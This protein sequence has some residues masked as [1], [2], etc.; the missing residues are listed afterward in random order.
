MRRKAAAENSAAAVSGSK[1]KHNFPE[2]K[3]RVCAGNPSGGSCIFK[4]NLFGAMRRKA[5]AENSAAAVSGSKE[6]HSSP[7]WKNRALAADRF[8]RITPIPG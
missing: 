5:A 6:K 7:E 1:E 3:G 8:T 4:I 2:R